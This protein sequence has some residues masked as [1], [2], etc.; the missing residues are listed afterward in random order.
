MRGGFETAT[1]IVTGSPAFTA[2]EVLTGQTPG[3]ASDVYSLG[4]TLFCAL[5]G[6]AA[7]ERR[8]GEQLI[9]QFVRITADP[10]PDLR[11]RNIADDVS[12]AVQHAMST[13][14]SDR[15][16]MIALGQALQQVQ[17]N[18]GFSIDEMALHAQPDETRPTK[19]KPLAP[20][21]DDDIGELPSGRSEG[22]L[23]VELTS[24][25]GRRRELLNIKRCLE[26][27]HL[28]TLAGFGGVG[29]TR[30]ALRTAE[31]MRRAFSDGT[32]LV[33]CAD[34]NDGSLFPDLVAVALGLR[35]QST[36]NL[37]ERLLNYLASRELLLI[38]DN[39]EQVLSAA[40]ELSTTLLRACPRIRILVT[41]REPLNV[42]GET[43]F[44]VP[45]LTI[46]D[47][48]QS[49]RLRGTLNSDAVALF[50]ER[51]TSVVSTFTLTD[52][53]AGAVAQIC[54]QL[55]G[56]PLSIELAAARLSAMSPEQI[57]QRLSDRYALLTRGS[58]NAPSRQQTMRLCVDWSYE[59][60]S[61]AEQLLWARLSVFAG[62][63]E[64]DS[65]EQICGQG[66][67]PQLILDTLTSLVDKS[68]LIREEGDSVVRFHEDCEHETARMLGS[69]YES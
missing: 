17:V 59:L 24:F 67:E 66:L 65:A 22:N 42:A 39:C 33:E 46:P 5:T 51:A 44:R 7:F 52:D 68:I 36:R 37:R 4:A 29:K 13:S 16:S 31:S 2:P 32:W 48:L 20:R 61:P 26:S 27:S 35:Y 10:T 11:E 9:A 50:A 57:L 64:W 41:S 14:A 45:P 38:L 21:I 40:A 19:P 28:V 49:P 30:L 43:V 23:P 6:H 18:H 55:D 1:G 12:T 34:L 53:N 69:N 54:H 15:C 63:A 60:C 62:S 56:L 47:R 3:P 25:V 58:R 8:S